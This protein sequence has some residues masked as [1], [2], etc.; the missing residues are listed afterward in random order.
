MSR[1]CVCGNEHSFGDSFPP[2]LTL[3]DL[4]LYWLQPV[5]V[6]G[7]FTLN[8]SLSTS[9]FIYVVGIE[10]PHFCIRMVGSG[11][12]QALQYCGGASSW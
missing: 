5:L 2:A 7:R 6:V 1:E 12:K 4:G 9:V 10:A 8:R 11:A 3:L